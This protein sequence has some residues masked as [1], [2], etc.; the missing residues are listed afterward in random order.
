MGYEGYR[1]NE[2][3][4]F[5][6]EEPVLTKAIV[7]MHLGEDFGYTKESLAELL[8]LHPEDIDAFFSPPEKERKMRVVL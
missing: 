6:A 7:N 5:A 1:V 2:P 4:E 8:S 3:V